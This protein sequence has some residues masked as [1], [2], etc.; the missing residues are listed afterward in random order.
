MQHLTTLYSQLRYI[1]IS[2][3]DKNYPG[4]KGAL[5]HGIAAATHD[6]LL[7]TDADCQPASELWMEKMVLPLHSG[8]DLVLGVSPYL[9]GKGLINKL[10]RYETLLTAIQYVGFA[11]WGIPYMSVGR[12]VAYTR[13]LF[14]KVNGFEG[15]TKTASGDD[16]LFVQ[17][18]KKNT[19]VDVVLEE[20]AFTWSA[21][22]ESISSWWKQKTRHYS[23]GYRYKPQ[24]LWLLGV[25]YLSKL[26]FWIAAV[27]LMLTF[28]IGGVIICGLL[29]I[30]CLIMARP[31]ALKLKTDILWQFLLLDL[32]YIVTV[33]SAGWTSLLKKNYSWK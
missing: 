33:T 5:A 18:V 30:L 25:F 14:N 2:N 32:L 8:A 28:F 15:L 17:K 20:Q 3:K 26:I 13:E 11:L 27:N 9:P 1:T 22:P 10:V 6:F 19:A 24:T 23:T 12:N 7:L 16:D 4:K 21:T 29:H 31:L